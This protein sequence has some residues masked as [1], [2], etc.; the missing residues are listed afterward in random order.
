MRDNGIGLAVEMMPKLFTMFAQAD[1]IHDRAEGGLG[2]GLALVRGI[3]ALHGGTVCA[4]SQGLGQGS[5]FVVTLP[6]SE[7]AIEFPQLGGVEDAGSGVGLRIVVADD[8]RDAA[9][10]CAALLE[11][12]GHH[13]QTAYSGRQ[14][15]ELAESFRP[16]AAFLDIG[17]PDMDG[18]TLAK[19][20]R[21]SSWGRHTLLVA[22]TGWGQSED[23]RRAYEAG[24]DHH[25]AKP[26]AA[27]AIESVLRILGGSV[28][29]DRSS[30]STSPM[31]R[32]TSE[33]CPSPGK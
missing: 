1:G 14:A 19:R 6:V 17:L 22:V 29:H 20:I 27:E 25:L 8:N 3:V 26:V 13:V 2:V 31:C 30:A 4:Q 33:R 18:Y 5:E 32:T 24:F 7:P 15:F 23:R 10:T 12:S 21:E 9:D 16:H 11:L 28:D